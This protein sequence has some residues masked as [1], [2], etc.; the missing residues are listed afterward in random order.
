MLARVQKLR[1][2]AERTTNRHEAENALLL[3]QRLLAEHDLAEVALPADEGVT[4][5]DAERTGRAVA[6]RLAL[7]G[8]VAPNFR[9]LAYLQRE[10]R[11]PG[12]AGGATLRFVGR[13]GDVALALEVYRQAAAAARNLARAHVRAR[14][15]D[16]LRLSP[17]GARQLSGAFLQGFAA[18]LA[19]RYAAQ[20]RAHREWALVLCRD[21]AVDAH[22][23]TLVGP[24]PGAWRPSRRT[25]EG[26]AWS[27]GWQEGDAFAAGPRQLPRRSGS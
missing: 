14:R 20:R 4:A 12:A 21:P 25:W 1:R 7:A 11:Q 3:A 18:G 6:W 24:G 13:P 27:A 2:V 15:H 8:A 22:F 23:A 19:Q 10:P 16:G 5:A 17:A 9:C 26:Q